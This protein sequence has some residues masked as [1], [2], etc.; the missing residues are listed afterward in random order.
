[1]EEIDDVLPHLW[2][3]LKDYDLSEFTVSPEQW[4]EL[5]KYLDVREAK[6]KFLV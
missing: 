3:Y 6:N 1:M 4:N 2:N 5:M